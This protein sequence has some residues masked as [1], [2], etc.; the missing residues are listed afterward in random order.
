MEG[1]IC[2]FD[3]VESKIGFFCDC[4]I[5]QTILPTKFNK[6]PR[7][8]TPAFHLS[9]F[10]ALEG[11]YSDFWA[12]IRSPNVASPTDWDMRHAS[13]SNSHADCVGASHKDLGL[14]SARAL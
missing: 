12:S 8:S 1:L 14:G 5:D 9:S 11:V 10:R 6:H 13:Y 2:G 7:L 4:S 3:V